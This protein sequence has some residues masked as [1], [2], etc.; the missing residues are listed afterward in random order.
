MRRR[1]FLSSV[2][3]GV[4]GS[5]PLAARGEAPDAPH[6]K[7]AT[8]GR[9]AQSP[10]YGVPLFTLTLAD[11]REICAQEIFA[12]RTYR[13]LLAGVPND[14]INEREL[15]EL[16]E[17]CHR[18]FLVRDSV[19]IPPAMIPGESPD[20]NWNQYPPIFVAAQFIS[21][22]DPHG[23][24][25]FSTLALGWFQT[26]LQPLIADDILAAIKQLDWTNRAHDFVF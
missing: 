4:A 19:I 24:I 15:S 7:L 14:E 20:Q 21:S 26:S 3:G 10:E 18:A 5:L 17:T 9:S 6:A 1:Q 12:C 11:G 2:V 8:A 16:K 22:L 25:N 23:E 13:G